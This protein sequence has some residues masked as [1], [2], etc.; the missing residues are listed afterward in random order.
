[1]IT[2]RLLVVLALLDGSSVSVL[3][4]TPP[5]RFEVKQRAAAALGGGPPSHD[6][7]VNKWSA[8]RIRQPCTIVINPA[9]SP[10]M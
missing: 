7:L 2:T 4:S 3:Y 10:N 8:Q 1:L 9:W 6:I 5:P